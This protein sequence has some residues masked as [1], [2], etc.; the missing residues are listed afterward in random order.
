MKL[1]QGSSINTCHLECL[2]NFTVAQLMYS[3]TLVEC[4]FRCYVQYLQP[5][6]QH[7]LF[8]KECAACIVFFLFHSISLP[9]PESTTSMYNPSKH[10][11]KYDVSAKICCRKCR[12]NQALPSWRLEIGQSLLM[13]PTPGAKNMPFCLES[14]KHKR[15]AMP[16]NLWQFMMLWFTFYISP[17]SQSYMTQL[18]RL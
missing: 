17:K 7:A 9:T 14:S 11:H 6:K 5:K 4:I 2:L 3:L 16:S 12:A 15:L 1:F 13:W 18:Y 8:H 10:L